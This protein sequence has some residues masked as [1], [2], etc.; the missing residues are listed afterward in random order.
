MRF[1]SSLKKFLE[2]TLTVDPAFLQYLAG[3][4]EPD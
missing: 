3:K 1:C 2:G 4:G